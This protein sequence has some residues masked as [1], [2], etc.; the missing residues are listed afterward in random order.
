M[1]INIHRGH[2]QMADTNKVFAKKLI[3][4]SWKHKLLLVITV[5]LLEC[6]HGN[7]DA[8]RLYDDLFMRRQY[9]KLVR[10]VANYSHPVKV[11]FGLKF[12]QL[13]NVVIHMSLLCFVH[14][15]GLQSDDI[16]IPV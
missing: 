14:I 11:E 15:I 9:N 4:S 2:V 13:I 12:A 1:G 10:P 7:P 3:S 8:R 6:C 16:K 5:T